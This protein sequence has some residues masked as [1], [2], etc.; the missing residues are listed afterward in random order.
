MDPLLNVSLRLR[1]GL[2]GPHAN[3]AFIATGSKYVGVRRAP[4][5]SIDDT[6]MP[7]LKT[8]TQIF[9]HSSKRP[10]SSWII[11][12]PIILQDFQ[13]DPPLSNL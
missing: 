7:R 3:C 8:A 1:L 11:E 10:N 12:P 2:F 9:S 13:S 6:G 4:T 5:G